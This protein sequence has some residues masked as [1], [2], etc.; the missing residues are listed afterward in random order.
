M[1]QVRQGLP[2]TDSH[3]Q[4]IGSECRTQF[5]TP[6][7]QVATFCSWRIP[8]KRRPD[9]RSD[10]SLTRTRAT[11]VSYCRGAF[12]SHLR[13]DAQQQ[14]TVYKSKVL[15]ST[16]PYEDAVD[17]G[18]RHLHGRAFRFCRDSK[19]LSIY[20]GPVEGSAVQNS[21]SN[22]WTARNLGIVRQGG[23]ASFPSNGSSASMV[24]CLTR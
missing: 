4:V 18:S 16:A 5:G 11:S 14:G 12:L 10:Q 8:S 6:Y 3:V 20:A 22:N 19:S 15:Y 24:H 7:R 13:S 17:S 2:R 9:D 21:R 23:C 1:S